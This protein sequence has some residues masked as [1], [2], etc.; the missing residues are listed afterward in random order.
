[1]GRGGQVYAPMCEELFALTC[2]AHF[3]QTVVE[4][5]RS[6]AIYKMVIAFCQASFD[7]KS[8]VL[9]QWVF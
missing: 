9:D 1:M 8:S 5:A 4:A 3:S 7:L 6:G 2:G